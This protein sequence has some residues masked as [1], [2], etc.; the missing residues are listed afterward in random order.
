MMVELDDD[1][2]RQL[3]AVVLEKAQ[4]HLSYAN[5]SEIAAGYASWLATF[6]RRVP[7]LRAGEQ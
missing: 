5:T 4:E 7:R 3:Y 6:A 1:E 2:A